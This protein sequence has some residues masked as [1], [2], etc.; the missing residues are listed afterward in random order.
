V[1]F[2]TCLWSTILPLPHPQN[3]P[4]SLPHAIII[5]DHFPF[6]PPKLSTWP[7]PVPHSFPFQLCMTMTAAGSEWRNHFLTGYFYEGQWQ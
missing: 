3:F 4:I 6:A 2:S 7:N 1:S 5:S